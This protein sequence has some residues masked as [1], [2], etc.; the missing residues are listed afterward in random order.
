LLNI[1]V[2]AGST[3]ALPDVNIAIA[4]IDFML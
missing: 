2:S 4:D 3:V 1:P